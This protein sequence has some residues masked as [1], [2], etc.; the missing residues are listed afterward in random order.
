[1]TR[2]VHNYSV[3][4]AT[5]LLISP[6]AGRAEDE[7][8][9]EVPPVSFYKQIRPIF[10]VRCHGCHQPARSGGEYVMTS[11]SKLLAGGETEVA[12]IVPN[13]PEE[14]YLIDQ[15]TPVDGQAEM[16]RRAPP[17]HEAE[18]DLVRKWVAEGARDDTPEGAVQRY[19]AEHP[20]TYSR[21]PVITSLD[22]SPDG[23][24]L[25]VSGFHEVLLHKADGSGLVTRLIGLSERIESVRFSPDGK[26]LAVTGGSPARMGE[27]QIWDVAKRKLYLSL[28]VTFDTV[29]GASWSPNKRL[30][31]FG[32]ADNTVRA[33]NVKTGKLVLNQGAHKDWVFDTV[34]GVDGSHLVSVAKARE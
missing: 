3:L 17:L 14:S 29:Y 9:P 34:F 22:Y 28:P 23:E 7:K 6:G 20:P 31:A 12:A 15:I 4:I 26:K 18:I 1:M 10:Q 13:K 8:Q 32:C 5:L 30:V 21:P 33:L 16:P 19:D 24:L 2:L 27:L 11:F 25:A